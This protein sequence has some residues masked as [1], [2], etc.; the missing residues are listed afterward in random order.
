M[1]KEGEEVLPRGENEMREKSDGEER[2]GK[3]RRVRGVFCVPTMMDDS[4]D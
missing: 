2:K 3:Q 4:V 1:K